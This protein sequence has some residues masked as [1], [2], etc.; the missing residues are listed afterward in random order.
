[1]KKL[2]KEQSD[3]L[4]LDVNFALT[5]NAGSGKTSVLVERYFK[6]LQKALTDEEELSPDNI[7][8]I[9]FTK[10]AAAEMLSRVVSRFVETYDLD[11]VKLKSGNVDFRFIDKL[12]IFR[13]KLTNARISTIH[14][15]CLQI[16][17][18]YPIEAG[19]PVN[20][21][22]LSGSEKL[23]LIE[24]AFNQTLINWLEN[25]VYKPK[26]KQIFAITSL[27]DLKNLTF[28][29]ISNIDIWENLVELYSK[30]FNEYLQVLLNFIF[31][32][33]RQCLEALLMELYDVLKNYNDLRLEGEGKLY[34]ENFF[35]QSQRFLKDDYYDVIFDEKLWELI[36]NF[37]NT[38]YQK[39]KFII[40]QRVFKGN[41]TIATLLEEI[42]EEF[43]KVFAFW[44]KL[45]EYYDYK[46]KYSLDLLELE[47]K[48]FETSKTIF[49]FIKEVNTQFEKLKYDEGLI[50]FSDMLVRTRDL[51]KNF[52]EV[53]EEVRSEIKYLL[54]DEFQDTD[55]IQF[56]I[57]KSLASPVD[58]KPIPNLFIVGD[59][60]Q[61]I[62]SFRNAD[63]RVFGYA[64]AFISELNSSSGKDNGILK[65][66]TTFRLR[67]EIAAFVDHIFGK[68]MNFN[69]GD[70]YSEFAIPYEP[71][72]VPS[73]K[74]D[75]KQEKNDVLS[76]ITF[77]FE[78]KKNDSEVSEI[79]GANAANDGDSLDE[80]LCSHI[81]SIVCNE[82]YKIFDKNIGDYR[83]IRYSD[84]AVISRKT[85]NLAKIAKV[86]SN[87]G[88]PFIFYGSKNFFSTREILD[89]VSFLKFLVNPKNDLALS[90]I[91]R[92]VFFGFT[93]EMLTN[94]ACISQ[95]RNLSFYEK[96]HIYY[97]YLSQLLESQ[98]ASEEF[99]LQYGRV[100]NAIETIEKIK[101]LVSILPINEIIHRILV[102]TEW[103]KKARAF[104][105]FEQMYAN[106]D[107]LLD[108]SREYV[109][110]GFRTI[111]DFI[112]D[113]DYIT[114]AGVSDVDR[115]GFV[116]SDAVVLLTIHSAKGLEFP[117]VYVHRIDAKT[118]KRV[119]IDVSRELGLIFQMEIAIGD[120]IYKFKPLQYMFA[121]EQR[122]M[123]LEAE[124]LRI[125]YVS[126][127]RASDYLIITGTI[128]ESK[129]K[130]KSLKVEERLKN[131]LDALEIEIDNYDRNYTIEKEFD[132]RVGRY[133][134]TNDCFDV[135]EEKIIVPINFIFNLQSIKPL[136]SLEIHKSSE[137]SES[138]KVFLLGKVESEISKTVFSSTRFNVFSNSPKDYIQSYHLGIHRNLM[139]VLK[140]SLQED[141]EHRDELILGSLIGN[142]IHF[143]LQELGAWYTSDGFYLDKLIE[144]IEEILYEQKRNL[145]RELQNQIVEQ[146]L[147]VIQTQLFLQNRE[148]ILNADKEFEILVPF[149]TNYLVAKID[150]LFKNENGHYEIWD[151]KSNN[152]N[153][154]E[155][156]EQVAKSYELQMKTYA[157]ALSQLHPEQEHYKARL[158][159]TRLARPNALD[160]E[161][162]YEFLWR[163]DE[164]LNIE[165]ELK[166]LAYKINN[167][168]L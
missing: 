55:H 8:A 58:G 6:I 25:P 82:N 101:P 17:S 7:V 26:L 147:N 149:D 140:S 54:V 13:N 33:Y 16:I 165:K 138:G 48:Y 81:K 11:K 46:R 129:N 103:H 151:W 137:V 79:E 68:L 96:L 21:R 49:T 69:I 74:L 122:K 84:I 119:S 39:G 45:I 15:F 158:L 113:V 73:E 154:L 111:L 86:F 30:D 141:Y 150:L 29:A 85:S 27:M 12:R 134:D 4:N 139:E 78:I 106:V 148:R 161:W 53:A 120:E 168:V 136:Q 47:K 95:D 42:T 66:T 57:V 156:M 10:K 18:N 166:D 62:Y 104:P 63:V 145:E 90:A 152:V 19:I 108:Y 112:D 146:C 3:A 125:H 117:V 38:I 2:T 116:A 77:L 5:A 65:L 71:F 14:S 34:I 67:P 9:T 41:E 102:E 92:S 107:E 135:V 40:R 131:I 121:S 32:T 167:L 23:Q 28:E 142:T 43:S 124:E 61:S 51:L 59:E 60:K 87:N 98:Q 159:F 100:K 155:Q 37:L 126:L 97:Y 123:E 133:D 88:I 163:E 157:F 132:I 94:I 24:D 160:K 75:T 130:D 115:F 118:D 164:I 72:V 20:F 91:L 44:S 22:E 162:T 50:D 64:K 80:M 110:M 128:K 76:P 127:T 70:L 89:I 1:M 36:N 56:E 83:V 52:P 143:C 153:S 31:K 93:D 109:S 114:R 144:T 105:N 99:E 35:V